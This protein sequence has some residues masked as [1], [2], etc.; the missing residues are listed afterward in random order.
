[1]RII[2]GLA[3][4]AGGC[5]NV[6]FS[7]MARVLWT[8]SRYGEALAIPNRGTPCTDFTRA[9]LLAREPLCRYSLETCSFVP[10]CT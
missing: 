7:D 9:F 10:R 2:T 4:Q 6:A 5:L 8:L 1:M 3:G